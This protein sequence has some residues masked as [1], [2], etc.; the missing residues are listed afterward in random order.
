[1]RRKSPWMPA[2][3]EIEAFDPL[4]SSLWRKSKLCV[5]NLK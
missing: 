5:C 1:L 2:A 3:F 4:S